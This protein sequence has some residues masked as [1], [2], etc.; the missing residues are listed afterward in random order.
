RTLDFTNFP[1]LHLEFLEE[2]WFLDVSGPAVPPVNIAGGRG[3]FVPS[4][5][6]R[7][8]IL[9]QLAINLR[10]QRGL[11]E[12]ADFTQ[13]RPEFAKINRP[14]ILARTNRVAAQVNIHAAREREGN[15]ERWRHEEVRLDALMHARLEIAV[16]R[17]NGGRDKIVFA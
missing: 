12:V 14:A 2:R 16:A 8:K 13:A 3:D 5:I 7:R 9:E 10:L 1:G 15:D 11:H 6:L 4:G 17:K